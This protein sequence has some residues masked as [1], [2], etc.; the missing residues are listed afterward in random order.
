MDCSCQKLLVA[1]HSWPTGWWGPLGYHPAGSVAMETAWWIC[2]KVGVDGRDSSVAGFLVNVKYHQQLSVWWKAIVQHCYCLWIG[3]N[4]GI[5]FDSKAN[6]STPGLVAKEDWL[7]DGQI[8]LHP[9]MSQQQAFKRYISRPATSYRNF[10][11]SQQCVLA[12]LQFLFPP[13]HLY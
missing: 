12:T 9:P 2:P 11:A 3:R 7:M 5:A 8:S 13:T 6:D 4:V 10:S 1:R